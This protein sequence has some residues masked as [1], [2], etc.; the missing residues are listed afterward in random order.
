MK[1]RF[2][3]LALTLSLIAHGLL[4]QDAPAE[5]KVTVLDS[6]ITAVT[7]YADRARVTREAT[8]ALPAQG[9]RFSFAK[10]P[11]WIDEGSV[12]VSLSPPPGRK[13][14]SSTSRFAALT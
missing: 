10:L 2:A 9:T 14:K 11:S 5:P 8:L 13:G 4:G 3:P 6:K 12:R 1:H 7:V